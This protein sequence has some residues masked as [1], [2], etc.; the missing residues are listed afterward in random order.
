LGHLPSFGTNSIR[1]IASVLSAEEKP[2][3]NK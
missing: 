1:I 3:Y 2:A